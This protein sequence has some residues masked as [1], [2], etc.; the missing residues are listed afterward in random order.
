[1][2]EIEF[3]ELRTKEFG[4]LKIKDAMS[5]KLALKQIQIVKRRMEAS[6]K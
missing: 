2:S 1:M 5:L 3:G 6:K 4:I